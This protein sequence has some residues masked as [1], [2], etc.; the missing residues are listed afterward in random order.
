MGKLW[1]DERGIDTVPLKLVVYLC[2]VG[3][4]IVLLA[5]GLKNASPSMDEALIERQM[6][7]LTSSL[8]QMQS[9][10]ARDLSDPYAPT[11]N[12]RSFEL[13]LPERLE[14]LS[15]GADP[16]PDNNGILTDT[17][18]D[19]LT[20]D[21]DVIY[22]KLTGGGKTLVQLDDSV[23]LREG[24]LT[25][26]RWMPNIVD[27]MEQAVVLT[28]TSQSVTFELVHD[29]G[30]TYTLSHLSDNVN[31]Y[32]NPDTSG[33]LPYGLVIYINPESIP[34]DGIT[35]AGVTVQVID[36][37]GREVQAEGIEIELDCTRGDLSSSSVV[38]NALGYARISLTSD[39]LGLGVVTARTSGLHE[40]R[41]EISYTLP[42][43]V[44]EFNEWILSSRGSG[45]G[46][47]QLKSGFQVEHDTLYDVTLTGWGTEAHWP[48]MPEEWPI[49]SIEV[50]GNILGEQEV[51]S[52]SMTKVPYGSIHL[53]E[54]THKLRVT[55]LN[56]FNVPL[57]GDRNLYVEKVKFS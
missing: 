41:G 32:I 37:R 23:R 9:G 7:E 2:L 38:T 56:D 49:A 24:V 43:V 15:F 45:G 40:G 35:A 8:E 10:Y 34:A 30:T 55:M 19:L 1:E 42:P 44:V 17:P 46:R 52:G 11:G 48:L 6:G 39:E 20:D 29:G 26:G 36:S 12:I 50:D 3:V 18:P 47:W 31:T 16:D 5:L 28:G 25:D 53:G 22:Y 14:Y 27:S 51:A 4:V 13:V 33:G 57:V 21:G 54:G